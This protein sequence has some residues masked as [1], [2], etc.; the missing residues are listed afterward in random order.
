MLAELLVGAVGVEKRL[1]ALQ[2]SEV[3]TLVS[4]HARRI[5]SK[6]SYS[7]LGFLNHTLP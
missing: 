3:F 7:T 1:K 6:V 2:I 4:I 5:I